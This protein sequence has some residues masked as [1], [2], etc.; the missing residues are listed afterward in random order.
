MRLFFGGIAILLSLLCLAYLGTFLVLLTI[1]FDKTEITSPLVAIRIIDWDLW[2][3]M[4]GLLAGCLTFLG[5]GI[6]LISKRRPP[7]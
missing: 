2:L 7:A 5:I 1:E 6:S 4:A 3:Y